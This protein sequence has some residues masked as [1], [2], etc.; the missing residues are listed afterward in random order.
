MRSE[1]DRTAAMVLVVEDEAALSDVVQAYLVKAGYATASARSGPEAVEM[2]RALAPDVIVLDLGLPGLDGLEVM[3]RIRTFSDCYVLI[4]TARSEEV[5]RLVGLSVGADDYLTKPF[6]VREL[7]ARVQAVLR[8]PRAESGTA[9]SDTVRTYGELEI[10][11]A[12]QEVRLAG[13]PL[14]LT[15]TERGLL[16][17]LALSPGQAFSR[18]QLM[19]AVWGDSWIGDDHL[20]DV[21]IANLRRKL[22]ESA[23][24]ARFI[25]TVRGIGYRMGKG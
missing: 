15:P 21:H 24:S 13:R 5:D 20:V 22:D 23:E 18:R 8:R 11:T 6:S 12:A 1:A 10:D 4:T 14:P 17:T 9:S 2:A 3:R 7:V 19:E 16:M 25:T